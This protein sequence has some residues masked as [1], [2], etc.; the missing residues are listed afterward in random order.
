MW[1]SWN[2]EIANSNDVELPKPLTPRDKLLEECGVYYLS[3][4]EDRLDT[5]FQQSLDTL[6]QTA[7]DI[8]KQIYLRGDQKEE[9]RLAEDKCQKWN[10]KYRVA[11]KLAKGN[12]HGFLDTSGG[13]MY[14]YK[15]I[16]LPI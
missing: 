5:H 4:G 15:V 11:D 1:I 7:P 16:E 10:A 9:T 12:A 2:K 8:R 3:S 13:V 14:A 6:E